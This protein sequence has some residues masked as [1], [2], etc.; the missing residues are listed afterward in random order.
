MGFSLISLSSTVVLIFI[1]SGALLPFFVFSGPLSTH[2]IRP[3]FI[4]SYF[5]FID[6]SGTFLVSPNGTFKASISGTKVQTSPSRYYFSITHVASDA[7]F[8]SANRNASMSDSDKLSLSVDGLRV[9]D[10]AGKL[11]WSTPPLNSE[12]AA[13]QLLET[14]N[15]LLVDARNITLWES[16][17]NPTDSIVVGQRLR[18]GK[19]LESALSEQDQSVGDYRLLVTD[20]DLLL[21][22]KRMT[23]FKLSMHEK[24]FKNSYGEVSFLAIN[25]TG[26]YLL[27]SDGSTAVIQVP[28]SGPSGFRIG[29]L[30]SEGRFV[31]S[32]FIGDDWVTELAGPVDDCHIPFFCGKIGLCTRKPLSGTCSCPPGFRVQANGEYIPTDTSLSLPSD[33]KSNANRNGS[34]FNSSVSYLQLAYGMDYFAND[35]NGP[36]EHR[37]NLSACQDICSHNCSCLAIF[38]ENASESCYLLEKNLGSIILNPRPKNDNRGYIKV[39]VHSSPENPTGNNNNN[40]KHNFPIAAL[41]LLPPSVFFLLVTIVAVAILWLRKNRLSK[42]KNNAESGRCNSS[43]SAELEMI[44]FPG[45]PRRFDYEELADATENFKTQIGSGGFGAVY[46]GTLSDKSVVAVKKITSLGVQ[47]KKDFCTEIAIIGNIHHVN[48]VRLKGFCVHGRQRFLVLEYMNRGSLDRPLFGNGPVLEWQ[49][50]VEIALGT[51]RGLAYLHSGCQDRIIHCD[52]KPE[53]ILLHDNLHVK[54]SDFGLSKLLSPE[55]SGLFTTMRG[56]RGYLAPE[57]LTNSSIS[58]KSDVYSYGMVLLEIV[59]GRKNSSFQTLSHSRE[60]SSSGGNG[61]SS[62]SSGSGSRPIYFPLLALEMHEKRRYAELADQRLEGRVTSEEV[63]KL[64]RI[65]LCCL[66]EEPALR[67][68]MANVV[69]MLEGGLP[70]GEPRVESLNFLRFYGRRFT[71]ISRLEGSN[72]KNQNEFGLINPTSNTSGLYNSLTYISSQQVSGPR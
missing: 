47:G 72:E 46:K 21:Q 11:L 27:E 19:S 45:L 52:V 42:T 10:E 23:Y 68:A 30:G 44:D 26:L 63:E 36:M 66:H 22:W 56:T 6:Q 61:L 17:E 35:F 70:L 28:L 64:V 7:I 14:G 38:H 40:Q 65:A 48:L 71:E 53:N 12:I 57:W 31:I 49:E 2:S 16:F 18:V 54:I 51:A 4:A 39:L 58:D 37:V 13:M 60:N 20:G 29:K 1:F 32:S 50:R 55:Q 25:D 41:V 69:S 9:A 59:R 67:P 34:Q 3:P 5:L 15:L 43:S 8:W 24:A 33:C 62:S